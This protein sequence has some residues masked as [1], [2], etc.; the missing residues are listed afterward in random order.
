VWASNGAN[1]ASGNCLAAAVDNTTSSGCPA[2]GQAASASSH[3]GDTWGPAN[4]TLTVTNL[5]AF[6]PTTLSAA[7]ADTVTVLVN[8]VAPAGTLT[9]TVTGG[10]T[11]SDTTDSIT[12]SPGDFLSVRVANA[13][14]GTFMSVPWRVS[15]GL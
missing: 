13:V 14:V 3:S 1:V 7:Q 8:G 12:L 4:T 11:C 9:C 2:A 15:F 6:S 5:F 10:N